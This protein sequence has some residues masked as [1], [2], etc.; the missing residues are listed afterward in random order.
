MIESQS[1]PENHRKGVGSR[2]LKAPPGSLV[3]SIFR[4]PRH[5]QLLV[6]AS[7]WMYGLRTFDF[8][9][10]LGVSL[11]TIFAA[12]AAQA[13]L[14]W[15]FGVPRFDP[16]SPLISALSLCLLLR[17]ASPWLAVGAAA[18]SIGSKFLIRSGTG[19]VF[20]PTNFGIVFLLLST[21][22]AWVAPGQWGSGA[23]LAFFFACAGILVLTRASRW[24]VSFAF[25]GCYAALLLARALYLGDPWA[26][27]LR[28][29]Q[30]GSLLLFAFF[31][32]SDPKTTPR[33]R[34]GRVAFACVVAVLGAGLT[35]NWFYPVSNGIFYALA[36]GSLSLPLLNAKSPGR[37]YRWGESR[38]M[39]P[40]GSL[41]PPV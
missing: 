13:L 14:S 11:I 2:M 37:P 26:I 4:D 38:P 34:R 28:Q 10:G 20:N 41:A 7:L 31:M 8:G 29:L 3:E 32:I 9:M 27:P 17:V 25:L 16:R 22:G 18:L 1:E 39:A 35:L 40:R 33:S 12:L 6:L 30:S 15:F 19:H 23:L 36:L 5:L 24:D 21:D